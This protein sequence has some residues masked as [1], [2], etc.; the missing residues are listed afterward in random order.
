MHCCF[1][2]VQRSPRRHWHQKQNL[3]RRPP[4]K[5]KRP[6]SHHAIIPTWPNRAKPQDVAQTH[7]PLPCTLPAPS[8]HGRTQL[9]VRGSCVRR[10][11]DVA[12]S[13]VW[14]VPLP[15]ALNIQP[16]WWVCQSCQRRLHLPRHPSR[17]R[18]GRTSLPLLHGRPAPHHPRQPHRRRLLLR[19]RPR[20]P[21][22][23]RPTA[24]P[25]IRAPSKPDFV[26]GIYSS[27]AGTAVA[28]PPP[29]RSRAPRRESFRTIRIPA[30][31]DP[32]L[33]WDE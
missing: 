8:W 12:T 1:H 6:S 11:S 15:I 16:R 30:R 4:P 19:H 20:I 13:I 14:S 32:V 2:L 28:T 27:R 5:P 22:A 26:P 33:S 25:S 9:V 24:P 17:H 3:L 23:A 18:Q 10:P 29:K 21:R 7:T 31:I